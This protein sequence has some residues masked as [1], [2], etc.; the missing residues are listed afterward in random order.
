MDLS[1]IIVNWNSAKFLRDC[2]GS[3]YSQVHDVEFEVIIVD[4]ASFD[5][6]AELVDH[7]FPSAIF[8]QSQENLGFGKA[9]NLGFMRSSGDLLLFL[10]PD[11]E[12]QGAAIQTMA[13][14]LRS[15]PNAGAIGCKLLNSD[16]SVQES[17]VQSFPTISNQLLNSDLLRRRFRN[18]KLWGNAALF[19]DCTEPV[20]VDMISGACLMVKRAAFEKVGQFGRELFMYADDLSLCYRL[21]RSGY[22]VCYDGT[23]QVTHH[24]G[25]STASRD[26]QHF[27]AV[28]QRESLLCFFKDT[29]GRFYAWLY[30]MTFAGVAVFRVLLIPFMLP[31][32]SRVAR[33]ASPAVALAKWTRVLRWALGLETWAKNI[34]PAVP[35]A[36]KSETQTAR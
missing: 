14:H 12:I 8:L 22:S 7:E 23:G 30:R 24:G 19:R 11:T 33:N 34:T 16:G 21:R 10:N 35:G 32:W 15:V 3:I 27:S 2:L 9:N 28:L 4:N 26:D 31:L 17:A 5:G 36:N 13:G 25:A 6:S 1:I 20:P 18:S 29:R